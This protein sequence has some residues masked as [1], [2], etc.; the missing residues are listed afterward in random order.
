MTETLKSL[1]R[2]IEVVHELRIKCPW[3]KEQTFDSLRHLTIEE[4][5]ELAEALVKKDFDEIR[6]ELGDLLLHIIFYARIA[7]EQ[8]KFD[9]KAITESLTD[10]LI[11]RHPH[12]YGETQLD[13]AA[14][15]LKNW[16]KIKQTEGKKKKS[17][18]AGVPDGLPSLVK[19]FRMQEKA[20]GVGFDWEDNSGAWEKLKEEISEFE[21]ESDM[22]KRTA[23][24]GDVFFAL[25]NYCRLSGINPDE[26]LSLTNLKFK[27]RFQY[28]EQ[29]AEEKNT[30]LSDMSLYEM[31]AF[32][33]EAKKIQ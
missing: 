33:N 23:E 10:K 16:E 6:T 18:L 13:N 29:K 17:V 24:M 12:I 9:L 27:H 14:D 30:P 11:R 25:I 21:A 26:A 1:E 2:L 8:N 15:V 22:E 19:A 31:E 3:D 20:A 7:E 4:T 32:W 28:I 5:Y